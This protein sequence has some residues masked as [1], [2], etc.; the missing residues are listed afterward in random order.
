MT[1]HPPFGRNRLAG[2]RAA[3]AATGALL[4]ILLAIARPG[5]MTI[6]AVDKFMPAAGLWA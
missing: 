5:M 3:G 4:L 2:R 6:G 1:T